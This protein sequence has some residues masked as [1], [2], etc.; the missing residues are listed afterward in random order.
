MSEP[1]DRSL[2]SRPLDHWLDPGLAVLHRELG[3]AYAHFN[4]L[5]WQG[6][7]PVPIIALFRQPPRCRRLGHYLPGAWVGADGSRRDELVIYA[8]LALARGIVE[9]LVT[10]VHEQVHVWQRYFGTPA[11]RAHNAQWHAEAA[12]VGLVTSG[13]AGY[14]EASEQFL[15]D[16]ERFHPKTGAIPYRLGPDDA[17]RAKGKLAKWTCACGY[18]VRVAVAAFDATCNR[19]HERFRRA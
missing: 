10:L 5:H 9:V 12:R 18:G 1:A 4:E 19:C 16:V 15:C 13:A 2:N 17:G 7:L 3:G 11:R 14:T 6:R 8:D